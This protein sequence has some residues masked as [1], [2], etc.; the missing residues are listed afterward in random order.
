MDANENLPRRRGRPRKENSK[1]VKRWGVWFDAEE[2]AQIEERAAMVGLP[3]IQMIRS[4]ALYGKITT[5]GRR[6]TPE[7]QRRV[8]TMN[9]SILHIQEGMMAALD[10]LTTNPQAITTI[11]AIRDEIRVIRADLFA[12]LESLQ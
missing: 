3:P 9:A 12:I 4:L 8:L 11:I 2:A 6:M 10:Q 7:E 5:K 1:R